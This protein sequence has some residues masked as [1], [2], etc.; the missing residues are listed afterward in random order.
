MNEFV[1]SRGA[2]VA[3]ATAAVAVGSGSDAAAQSTEDKSEAKS[4][5]GAVPFAFDRAAFTAVLARPYPHRQLAAPQTFADATV[6]LSHFR[7]SLAAYADPNGFAAGPNSLHCAAVL[8]AG[9]SYTMVLDDAMYAKYPIGLLADEEMR[10]NDTSARAYWTALRK[11]P[12]NDFVR[13][14][15]DQ[16]VSFFVCNNA[17]S[18][19]AVELARRAA[20]KDAPATREQ[21]VAIHDDLAAHFVMGTMLVPAGVAAVNAAQEARFTFLP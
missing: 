11:N 6:A 9:R 14:L 15:T 18:G 12:M 1:L 17:L 16:G 10:P 4:I 3:S 19:F 13:P 2:F 5:S 7:N 8:Y 21:V 20:T